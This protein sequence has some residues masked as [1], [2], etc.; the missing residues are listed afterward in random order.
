MHVGS[1]GVRVSRVRYS[2]RS[3]RVVRA[4]DPVN[5]LAFVPNS[6][7]NAVERQGFGRNNKSGGTRDEQNHVARGPFKTIIPYGT[8]VLAVT[9]QYRMAPTTME[10]W[11]AT[12][13]LVNLRNP[14][15]VSC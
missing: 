15:L 6:M 8:R 13:I 12:I 14:P 7:V 10:V 3:G 9:T 4:S 2:C 1:S 11:L 5:G